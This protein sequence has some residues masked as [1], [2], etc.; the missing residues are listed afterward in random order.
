VCSNYQSSTAVWYLII[1]V[2]ALIDQYFTNLI[3]AFSAADSSRLTPYFFPQLAESIFC[4]NVIAKPMK[5][6]I[7]PEYEGWRINRYIPSFLIL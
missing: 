7:E 4:A 2:S 1:N 5:D 3:I 6:N